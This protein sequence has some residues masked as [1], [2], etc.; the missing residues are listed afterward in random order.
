MG[1]VDLELI[2]HVV[3]QLYQGLEQKRATETFYKRLIRT[4]AE[5]LE[6]ALGKT[7]VLSGEN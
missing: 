2:E 5:E 7:N 6:K 1:S 4:S 3:A